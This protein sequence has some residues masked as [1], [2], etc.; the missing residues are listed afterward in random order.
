MLDDNTIIVRDENGVEKHEFYVDIDDI[1]KYFSKFE[2]L[3]EVVEYN[4]YNLQKSDIYSKYFG[5]LVR[6]R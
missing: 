5:I 1:V 4:V 6:K 3:D 2:I